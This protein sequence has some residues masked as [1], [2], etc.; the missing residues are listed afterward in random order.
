M[1]DIIIYCE[2]LLEHSVP[3]YLISCKKYGLQY[4]GNTVTPFRLRLS[5]HKSLIPEEG[6][7]YSKILVT[8]YAG[9]A[10]FISLNKC[11]VIFYPTH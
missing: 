6:S 11:I 8:L 9:R 1:Y 5:N 4:V 2:Y 10:R 7:L 3:M